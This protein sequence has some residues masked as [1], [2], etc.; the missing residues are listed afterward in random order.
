[1]SGSQDSGVIVSADDVALVQYQQMVV[2]CQHCHHV[3]LL[4]KESVQREQNW[5]SFPINVLTISF[6]PS[7]LAWKCKNCQF[8]LSSDIPDQVVQIEFLRQLCV[9]S[10]SNTTRRFVT[11][12]VARGDSDEDWDH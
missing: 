3:L 10:N 7:N 11:F 2:C 8:N 1:M 5:T 4:W 9:L 12:E 6:D